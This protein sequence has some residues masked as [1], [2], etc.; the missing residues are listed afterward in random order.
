MV[1]VRAYYIGGK[2]YY[3]KVK[4]MRVNGNSRQEIVEYYGDKLPEGVE[5]NSKY[6]SSEAG[7]VLSRKKK[8]LHHAIYNGEKGV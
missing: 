2:T 4:S 8:N 3:A 1:Y 7:K 5:C 6:I